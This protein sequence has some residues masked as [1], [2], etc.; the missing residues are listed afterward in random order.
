MAMLT[1]RMPQPSGDSDSG[2][3]V[4]AMVGDGVAVG[5]GV[6]LGVGDGFTETAA[7]WV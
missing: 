3:V 2:V 4:G 7:I 5:L 1:Y 6:G